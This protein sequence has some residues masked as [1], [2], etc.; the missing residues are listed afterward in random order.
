[1][2][3]GRAS[4]RPGYR[5]SGRHH[6]IAALACSAGMRCEDWAL[7]AASYAP[8]CSCGASFFGLSGGAMTWSGWSLSKP[9]VAAIDQELHVGV[10]IEQVIDA[11]G[12]YGGLVVHTPGSS[13]PDP[14]R[15]SFRVGGDGG[16]DRVLLLLAGHEGPPA[17]SVRFGAADLEL[18]AVQPHQEAV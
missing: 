6:L 18:G 1:M 17:G 13:R 15:S 14:H 4:R 12:A 16:L 3:S 10:L 11:F 5:C 2:M 8:T 9:R 7:R